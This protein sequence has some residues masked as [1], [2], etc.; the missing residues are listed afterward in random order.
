MRTALQILFFVLFVKPLLSLLIGVNI[1]GRENL[2]KA[3]QFILI[4]NHNSHLDTLALLNLFPLSRLRRI[5]PVAASD[6]FMS[7]KILRWF[8]TTMMNILPIPRSSFTR[9]NNPLTLMGEVLEA[10]DSLI[11]FPEGSRGEPE[12]IAPFKTG[13]A[14]VLEKYPEV[15][16]IPVFIK[17]MGK[18]LPRG[19]MVLVPFFCDMA[20]GAPRLLQGSRREILQ[21]L[22]TAVYEL[23][24]EI[25]RQFGLDEELVQGQEQLDSKNSPPGK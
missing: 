6:Y 21:S 3:P 13:I 8:S 2:S 22:E 14:H 18:A 11:L 7:N 20:I 9:A 25:I 17:G 10:G 15:P 23:R 5:H 12:Q 4:A 1:L 24:E 19:E 16:V